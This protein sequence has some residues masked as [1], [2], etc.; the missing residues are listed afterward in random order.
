MYL[1]VD[2][3][4]VS[5]KFESMRVFLFLVV[6]CE[7]VAAALHSGKVLRGQDRHLLDAEQFLKIFRSFLGINWTKRHVVAHTPP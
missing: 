3:I 5:S 2:E 1:A 4:K 6:L 7:L